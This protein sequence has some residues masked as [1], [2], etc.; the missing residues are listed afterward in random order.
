[1]IVASEKKVRASKETKK[2]SYT[3]KKIFQLN[4]TV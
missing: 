1:M 2:K 4:K 3:K